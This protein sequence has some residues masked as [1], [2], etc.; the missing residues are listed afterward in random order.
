MQK[1]NSKY[2]VT[3]TKVSSHNNNIQASKIAFFKSIYFHGTISSCHQLAKPTLW[4][5]PDFSYVLCFEFFIYLS[6]YV[7][8]CQITAECSSVKELFQKYFYQ[9]Q[10]SKFLQGRIWVLLFFMAQCFFATQ[11]LR[12][13][14]DVLWY[15]IE[16]KK[17]YS[18]W[19]LKVFYGS[20]LLIASKT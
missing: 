1:C 9:C 16:A 3:F 11:N 10:I 4:I 12:L 7:L 6:H 20:S 18:P 14:L 17:L 13:K 15:H 19:Y 5:I 2:F 8:R